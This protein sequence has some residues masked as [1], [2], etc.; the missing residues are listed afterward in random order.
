ML[1]VTGTSLITGILTIDQTNAFLKATKSFSIRPNETFKVDNDY[2]ISKA[3]NQAVAAGLITVVEELDCV[4]S[5]DEMFLDEG[6]SSGDGE[7]APKVKAIDSVNGIVFFEP[8]DTT[9]Y[10]I[11]V[12]KYTRFR[13]GT[14]IRSKDGKVYTEKIGK[15]YKPHRQ[16][17][18]NA[19]QWQVGSQYLQMERKRK[20][21]KFAFLEKNTTNRS[22]LSPI[23]IA[24][25]TYNERRQLPTH[26]KALIIMM[27][28]DN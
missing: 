1:T 21:F 9:K 12:F 11:E 17:P 3:F 2:L 22:Q 8:Y 4:N 28:G 20:Y 25:A 10:Q 5:S 18:Y 23:T 24:T 6:G 7:A 15:R 16:L 26:T 13:K 27:S 19:T 14:H